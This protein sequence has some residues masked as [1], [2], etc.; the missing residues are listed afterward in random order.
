MAYAVW[1]ILAL[2]EATRERRIALS[3]FFAQLVL[4]ALWSWQF[5]GLHSPSAGLLN[6]V[7]QWLL[8][9]ATIDRFR[10]LDPIAALCLVPLTVWVAFAA[11]LSYAIWRLNG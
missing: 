11:A 6:I 2:P 4:N 10:R 9:L 1:R 5:F 3:M 7:P 8:I